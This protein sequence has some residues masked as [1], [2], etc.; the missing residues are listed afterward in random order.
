M[1]NGKLFCLFALS[2]ILWACAAPVL[3]VSSITWKTYSNSRY[4]F[5][6][7]YPNNWNALSAPA[8]DDGIAL[9]SPRNNNIEIRGW[10]SNEL[11]PSI[12]NDSKTSTKGNFQTTQGL[13]GV[14][15]VEIDNPVSSMTLTLNS[16]SGEIPVARTKPKPGIFQLLSFVLL[17]CPTVSDY[18]EMRGQEAAGGGR[19]KKI[20]LSTSQSPIPHFRTST[21]MMSEQGQK[22]GRFS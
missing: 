12:T 7:P 20:L 22:T 2:L 19:G 10:A 8:N 3:D 1:L 4:G 21:R 13:S 17:H 18:E 5:E 9:I 15:L 16:E 14:L 6:F 11:P